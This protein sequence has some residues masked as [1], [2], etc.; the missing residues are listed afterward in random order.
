MQSLAI[1]KHFDIDKKFLF[2]FLARGWDV[3]TKVIKTF[4]FG[5]HPKTLRHKKRSRG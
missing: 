5:C 3:R 2:G 4:R 1:V